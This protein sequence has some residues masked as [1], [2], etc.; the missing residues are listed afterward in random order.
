M[1]IAMPYLILKTKLG[2]AEMHFQKVIAIGQKFQR[3]NLEKLIDKYGNWTEIDKY[4]N[5]IKQFEIAAG[6][7][8]SDSSNADALI[9]IKQEI[10][11]LFNERNQKTLAFYLSY[12]MNEDGI[13]FLFKNNVL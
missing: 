5:S 9:G 7:M 10:Q 13:N 12:G 4:Y 1:T 6:N 2:I 3:E 8:K 11:K